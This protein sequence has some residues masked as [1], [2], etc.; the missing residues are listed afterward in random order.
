MMTLLRHP[1]RLWRVLVVF[2]RFFI[3]PKLPFRAP[4]EPGAVRMRLA[5]E[6]LGGAWVKLGQMLAM[7]FDLLPPAY[8]S[9]L[10]KLLGQVR[11]FSY[12]DVR[13]I[14]TEELGA[15]PD[16]V[17]A[18]FE[19]RSFAAASI[20]QVH[21]AVLQTGER[22]AVKVQRPGIRADFR[23]DIGLM[24]AVSGIID[25]SRLFGGTKSRQVIDEFARWTADELDYLVEAR[26]AA[27]LHEHAVGERLERIARMYRDYTTSR[28]LT[29]ELI[30]GISLYEV[31]IA[32]RNKDADYL[33]SLRARGYDPDRIVRNLDWNMLNQVF[34]HGY[35]HADLHPANL[36]VLPGNAIGYVDYGI[37]GSL[38]DDTRDSLTHYS[39]LLFH[40][41]VD[42]AVT[43][44]MRWLAPTTTTD[45]EAARTYLV[46]VH[47]A[48]VYEMGAFDVEARDEPCRRG[49]RSARSP[50]S[51]EPVLAPRDGHHARDP[52]PPAHVLTRHRGLPE[53]AR[54]AR[55]NPPRA[56]D[57]VR[58]ACERPAL[59]HALHAPAGAR[60]CRSPPGHGAVLRGVRPDSP[61]GAVPRIH[62]VAGIVHR[63]GTVDTA[64]LPAA[65]ASHSPPAGSARRCGVGRRRGAVFRA[66]R[67][68]RD[69]AH[70]AGRRGLF[71]GPLRAAR[72]S[73]CS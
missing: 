60:P 17:F 54:D 14:V 57:Q 12:D 33:A 43:E 2:S 49:G 52:R 1:G 22:V 64:R 36:F 29:S 31:M 7:R 13:S 26:Q 48:F 3:L 68:G 46:S 67:A 61:G 35:F 28:V 40:G 42:A 56:R 5:I 41:D 47:R 19:E 39:W 38:P 44:L 6:E 65:D 18:R 8:C 9:E 72:R 51:R 55:N 63:R 4:P 37:V 30:E 70:A 58:P 16:E 66:S 23:S 20:G 69:T 50:A 15:P 34:V 25:R 10:L 24:Y 45:P 32:S 71:V 11:P 73:S 27:L 21:R 59:L 62:R 53:D